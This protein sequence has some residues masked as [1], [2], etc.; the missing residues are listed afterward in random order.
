MKE[1]I[2]KTIINTNCPVFKSELYIL[3]VWDKL[4]N[5]N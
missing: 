5:A 4:Y 1:V 2:S 3:L